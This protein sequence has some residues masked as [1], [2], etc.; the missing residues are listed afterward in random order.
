MQYK[1]AGRIGNKLR[2]LLIDDNSG[3]EVA[4]NYKI[5]PTKTERLEKTMRDARPKSASTNVIHQL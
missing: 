3:D 1:L 2:R 5:A 4:C